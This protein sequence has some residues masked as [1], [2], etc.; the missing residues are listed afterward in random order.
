MH[1]PSGERHAS[2]APDFIERL[3]LDVENPQG[4]RDALQLDRTE[5][6]ENVGAAPSAHHPNGVRR[7]DLAGIGV[8]TE[9]SRFYHWVAVVVIGIKRRLSAAESNA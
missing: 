1:E 2:L 6:L 5:P 9:T 3:P 7:Q 4:L 8:A